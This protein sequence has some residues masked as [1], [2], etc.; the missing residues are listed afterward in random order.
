M[1]LLKYLNNK[2]LQ[3]AVFMMMYFVGKSTWISTSMATSAFICESDILKCIS[4]ILI[5][6]ALE[7]EPR[8]SRGKTRKW[9]KRRN[10]KGAYHNLVKELR[11]E[12]TAGYKE[13][14]R[15]DYECFKLVNE[16]FFDII[17]L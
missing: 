7:D 4:A 11:M 3:L 9:I 16:Y 14:M 17:N 2:L 10:E 8:K 12:D 13:F 1:Q 6:E 15:M 5:L